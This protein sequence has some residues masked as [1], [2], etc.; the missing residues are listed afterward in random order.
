VLLLDVLCCELSRTLLFSHHPSSAAA[1][2]AAAELKILIPTPSAAAAAAA[3]AAGMQ[4]WGHQLLDAIDSSLRR[5][6]TLEGVYH[7]AF[8]RMVPPL[9]GA[10]VLVSCCVYS[11]AIVRQY[12]T[13]CNSSCKLGVRVQ[14]GGVPLGLL[15]DGTATAGSRGAGE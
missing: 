3:A 15:Q 13:S 6:Y 8:Y 5:Q 12:S 10:E 2:A 7:W 1:A 14:R 4:W 9:L 11:I